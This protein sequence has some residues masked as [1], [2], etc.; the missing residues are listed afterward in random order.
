MAD[1]VRH[2]V[3]QIPRRSA[4]IPFGATFVAQTERLGH[5]EKQAFLCDARLESFIALR[6]KGS[7][8]LMS[9]SKLATAIKFK[10]LFSSA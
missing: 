4:R 2:D 6:A 9:A 1:R 5:R 7:N 3:I 10:I 8:L